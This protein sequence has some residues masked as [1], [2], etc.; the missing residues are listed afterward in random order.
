MWIEALGILKAMAL[1]E[2]AHMFVD[3]F[4]AGEI[5]ASWLMNDAIL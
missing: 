4:M 1:E 2:Q 5:H 3:A